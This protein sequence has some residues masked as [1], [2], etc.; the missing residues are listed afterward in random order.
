MNNILKIKFF[1]H[2]ITVT[3]SIMSC[4]NA[5]LQNASDLSHYANQGQRWSYSL[6]NMSMDTS[7][8]PSSVSF[9]LWIKP[10]MHNREIKGIESPSDQVAKELNVTNLGIDINEKISINLCSQVSHPFMAK[11]VVTMSKTEA[12]YQI[13]F[14]DPKHCFDPTGF[15]IRINLPIDSTIILNHF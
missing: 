4:N 14:N 10:V 8:V 5:N 12:C 11:R 3:L 15:D 6:S 2:L 7:E 9:N 13:G 1:L